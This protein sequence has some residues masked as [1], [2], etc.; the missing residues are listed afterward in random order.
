MTQKG[1]VTKSEKGF[2]TIQFKRGSA[3]ENCK[4][5][6]GQNTCLSIKLKGEAQVGDQ[7][8]VSM[9][10]GQVAKASLI[11]Y[12]I[13]LAGLMAGLL[14]GNS[15]GSEARAL[16]FALVGLLAGGAVIFLLD[17]KIKKNTKWAPQIIEVIKGGA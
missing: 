13:P 2:L 6:S 1:I 3:C 7:V 11:A 8:L 5:C 10:E 14:I 16:V 12:G 9:P 15:S 4:G 17:K